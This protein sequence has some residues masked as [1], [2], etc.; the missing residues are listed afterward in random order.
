MI[1]RDNT[2]DTDKGRFYSNF[3]IEVA[4]GKD[5][6][7][8]ASAGSAALADE[9]EEMAAVEPAEMSAAEMSAAEMDGLAEVT[10]FP[11]PP[12][13][14]RPAK[15]KSSEKKPEAPRSLS[16]LAD[17][18]SIDMMMKDSANLG[19]AKEVDLATDEAEDLEAPLTSEYNFEEGAEGENIAAESADEF[20]DFDEEDY[21]DEE[22][23]DGWGGGGRKK[24]SK[25]QK[26]RRERRQF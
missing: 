1:R 4:M 26:P 13:P 16:S 17:L 21:E 20:D 15:S 2:Q 3:W 14:A 6:G 24:P 8:G 18:A 10:D 19:D 7:Q 22:E 12:Q 5:G 25:P 9:D 11:E 23:A